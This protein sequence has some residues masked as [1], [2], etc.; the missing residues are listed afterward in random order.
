MVRPSREVL[1]CHELLAVPTGDRDGHR[2]VGQGDK[3]A[4]GWSAQGCQAEANRGE[5]EGEVA[6]RGP[7]GRTQTKAPSLTGAPQETWGGPHVDP[8]TQGPGV[9]KQTLGLLGSY[10]HPSGFLRGATSRAFHHSR[11]PTEMAGRRQYV[12][13][14]SRHDSEPRRGRSHLAQARLPFPFP[15]RNQWSTL[16]ENYVGPLPIWRP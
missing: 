5:E 10:A 13:R 15:E 9:D 11:V 16:L 12:G 3:W 4:A 1:A 8:E 2:A 7:Q 14:K 6:E